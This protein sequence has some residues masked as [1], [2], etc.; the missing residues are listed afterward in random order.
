MVRAA[1][2]HSLQQAKIYAYSPSFN[3]TRSELKAATRTLGPIDIHCIQI[4]AAARWMKPVKLAVR[5]S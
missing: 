1:A 3:Q 4:I 5:L 2:Y